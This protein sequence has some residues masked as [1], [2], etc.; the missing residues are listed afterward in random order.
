[1]YFKRT[2]LAAAILIASIQPALATQFTVDSYTDDSL[3]FTLT[4]KMPAVAPASLADGP[5]EIDINY[6]G[7]LWI[8]GDTVG[9]NSL[10]A[11]PFVGSGSFEGGNTGGFSNTPTDY[12]WLYFANSLAGLTGSGAPVELTW[13]GSDFLNV[14]GTG[15]ISLYWGNL[16][17]GPGTVGANGVNNELLGTVNIV[18]GKIENGSAPEP[19]TLALMGLALAGLAFSRRKQA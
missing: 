10:S 8:G 11:S 1:V 16:T 2:L 17:D 19:A 13:G 4:G 3:T 14:A 18:D 9:S 15:T 5:E 12:S 6:S 7:N